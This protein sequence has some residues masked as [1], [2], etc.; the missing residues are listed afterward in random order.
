[1]A[2]LT[3]GRLVLADVLVSEQAVVR[4]GQTATSAVLWPTLSLPSSKDSVSASG[5]KISGPTYADSAES[6]N[7]REFAK[8]EPGQ[9][10]TLVSN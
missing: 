1:V 4:H 5:L 6:Q 3:A 7:A 10:L 8:R 9:A 2:N